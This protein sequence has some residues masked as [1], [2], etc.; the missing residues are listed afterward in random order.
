[1]SPDPYDTQS[2]AGVTRFVVVE[3]EVDPLAGKVWLAVAE[4]PPTSEAPSSLVKDL[5]EPIQIRRCRHC[6]A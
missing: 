1:V 3:E 6:C 5:V 2:V 4:V